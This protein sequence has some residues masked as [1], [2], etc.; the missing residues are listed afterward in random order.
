MRL[1]S[2]TSTCQATN[3]LDRVY[4]LLGL[5]SKI[6][7]SDQTSLFRADYNL[8]IEEL[9]V[10]VASACATEL[11]ILTILSLVQDRESR[12]LLRLPSW[13]PDITAVARWR[14][15]AW[16]VP[17]FTFDTPDCSLRRAQDG[18]LTLTSTYLT[19]V[20]DIALPF[21]AGDDSGL[22]K[23]YL[24]ILNPAL[25]LPIAYS[26]TQQDGTEVL[27]RTLLWGAA[28]FDEGKEVDSRSLF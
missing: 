20:R 5:V 15:P 25:T 9:C 21:Q 6:V 16:T 18:L 12:K 17:G 26:K 23:S 14:P 27:L 1:F 11:P 28:L 7:G 22:H 13:V 24:S 3:L 10:Q 2:R 4:S 8:P 19:A